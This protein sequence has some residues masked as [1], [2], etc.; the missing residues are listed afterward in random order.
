M[1]LVYY[2][3]HHSLNYTEFP[4]HVQMIHMVVRYIYMCIHL[5]GISGMIYLHQ[6]DIIHR[7][8]KSSNGKRVASVLVVV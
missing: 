8:L 6:K 3:V 7:D 4:G 2:Y 1:K 5:V